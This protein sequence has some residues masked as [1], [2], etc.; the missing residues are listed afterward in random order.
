MQQYQLLFFAGLVCLITGLFLAVFS[1]AHSLLG[2]SRALKAE[3]QLK[4]RRY[5][6]AI[7]GAILLNVEHPDWDG[8]W[9]LQTLLWE[10]RDFRRAM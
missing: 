4:R 8:D 6:M 3:A 10:Y 9:H 7:H 1:W 5:Q 2:E